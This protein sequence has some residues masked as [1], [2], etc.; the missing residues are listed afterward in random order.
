MRDSVKDWLIAWERAICARD[1]RAGRALFDEGASG[2]G[3]VT[4][5]THSLD[6]LVNRQWS[7]VWPR[8]DGFAFDLRELEIRVSPDGLMALAHAPW[9][10]R[11]MDAHGAPR[12]RTGRCTVVLT[13]AAD[14]APWRCVHTHFS[15]WPQAADAALIDLKAQKSA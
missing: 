13:R 5:R 1:F 3:T 15:M 2:F 9:T 6:D 4:E 7:V 10:S 11:G 12:P 8:T 14:T